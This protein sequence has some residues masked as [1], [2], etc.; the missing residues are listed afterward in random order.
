MRVLKV[1]A[2][3]LSAVALAALAATWLL[4]SCASL[5]FSTDVPPAAPA[6]QRDSPDSLLEFF[7]KA[8]ED[9]SIGAYGEALMESYRYRFMPQDWESVGVTP[10]WPFWGRTEDVAAM[11]RLFESD[12]LV[13]I[14]CE[15]SEVMPWF[16]VP[17]GLA[18]IADIDLKV[19]IDD[20]QK[21]W[22]IYWVR[23]SW[24][25][26]TVKPDPLNTG[27]WVISEIVEAIEPQGCAGHL[28]GAR[29][30]TEAT[31]FGSIKAMFKQAPG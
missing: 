12:M 3:S 14:T 19:E 22:T 20:P 26:F 17:G 7:C 5:D 9:R 18:M 31:T 29:S 28:V 8:L 6:L 15:L 21:G 25:E 11:E 27:L 4:M 16:Y 2:A 24:L 1:S 10:D 13:S 23:E 30:A